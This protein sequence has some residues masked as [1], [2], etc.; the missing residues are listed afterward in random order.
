MF[1]SDFFQENR[2][3]CTTE[4]NINRISNI[5]SMIAFEK[6][7]EKIGSG[8]DSSEGSRMVIDFQNE[9]E[10]DR[11][12]LEMFDNSSIFN[13]LISYRPGKKEKN[14]QQ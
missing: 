13:K 9:L 6:K 7:V 10:E 8:W 2:Q 4:R 5:G 12:L 3:G 1:P 14:T 11:E